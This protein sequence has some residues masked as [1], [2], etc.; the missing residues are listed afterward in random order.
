MEHL[1]DNTV[2]LFVN[3]EARVADKEEEEDMEHSLFLHYYITEFSCSWI[4]ISDG[5]IKENPID[6]YFRRLHLG[7]RCDR[8]LCEA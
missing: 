3:Y 2:H 1:C 6:D 4:P 7:M 5:F 8:P